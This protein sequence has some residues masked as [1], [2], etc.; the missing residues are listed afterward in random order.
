MLIPLPLTKLQ[1][2]VV[3]ELN[4]AGGELGYED[5]ALRLWPKMERP[6]V[7]KRPSGGGPYAW[8]MPLGRAL[9]GLRLKSLVIQS[10]GEHGR[11]VRLLSKRTGEQCL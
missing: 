4:A 3:A 5:L 7:W 8:A 1:A 11:P 10:V 2:R 9:S 6:E